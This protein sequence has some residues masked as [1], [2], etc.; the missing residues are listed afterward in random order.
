MTKQTGNQ[1]HCLYTISPG[2]QKYLFLNERPHEK[3][4]GHLA[5]VL[6]LTAVLLFNWLEAKYFHIFHLPSPICNDPACDYKN[7]ATQKKCL[8]SND[9]IHKSIPIRCQ[10]YIDGVWLCMCMFQWIWNKI[11]ERYIHLPRRLDKLYLE[12]SNQ[13]INLETRKRKEEKG[14]RYMSVKTSL[15]KVN[16][17]RMKYQKRHGD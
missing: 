11:L 2:N 15:K 12:L 13:I 8:S 3:K 7:N 6:F 1:K 5:L 4:F 16:I 14:N 17:W 10:S 9:N